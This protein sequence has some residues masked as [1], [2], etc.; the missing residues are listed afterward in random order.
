MKGFS[1][2]KLTE[3]QV[4][5]ARERSSRQI[6]GSHLANRLEHVDKKW[7]KI[8]YGK[9]AQ[10]NQA[11]FRQAIFD[12]FSPEREISPFMVARLA[13]ICRREYLVAEAEKGLQQ[14][15]DDHRSDINWLYQEIENSNKEKEKDVDELKARIMNL[16]SEL[17]ATK[18]EGIQNL[19]ECL[20]WKKRELVRLHEEKLEELKTMEKQEHFRPEAQE[21]VI[22][23]NLLNRSDSWVEILD[24][25]CQSNGGSEWV[26]CS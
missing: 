17:E 7:R 20:E 11:I 3:L 13:E 12:V 6:E 19:R 9:E 23:E 1:F 22:D 25:C 2:S 26:V 16:K 14:L 18:R 8:L 5:G 15:H 10:K 21:A 4:Q 24:D